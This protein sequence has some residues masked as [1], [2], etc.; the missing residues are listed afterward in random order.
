MKDPSWRIRW[1][2]I[3]PVPTDQRQRYQREQKRTNQ[4]WTKHQFHPGFIVPDPT[5]FG[6]YETLF[7]SLYVW[8]RGGGGRGRRCTLLL[9]SLLT[10]ALVVVC[11]SWDCG[12]S[13]GHHA[14]LLVANPLYVP[15]GCIPSSYSYFGLL[16]IFFFVFFCEL[17]HTLLFF[18]LCSNVGTSLIRSFVLDLC[19]QTGCLYVV[20]FVVAWLL[21]ATWLQEC[22]RPFLSWKSVSAL[23]RLAFVFLSCTLVFVVQDPRI[24]VGA[25]IRSGRRPPSV[26]EIWKPQK[27]LRSSVEKA[28]KRYHSVRRRMRARRPVTR[29]CCDMK[30]GLGGQNPQNP[31]RPK[32]SSP[33]SRIWAAHVVRKTTQVFL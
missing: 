2:V 31:V 5:C 25:S 12:G 7:F 3:K 10:I 23:C 28:W 33:E 21:F 19:V 18:F 30:R 1:Y 32:S 14:A 16:V 26:F 20:V 15:W 17:P 27:R 22:C 9:L 8:V 13:G 11:R 6:Q 4:F 29:Q 24:F